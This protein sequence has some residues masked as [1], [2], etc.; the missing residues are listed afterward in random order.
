MEKITNDDNEKIDL[1]E[2]AL[3]AFE[4]LLKLKMQVELLGDNPV[5]Y[6]EG[7]DYYAQAVRQA[8]P[9]EP[10]AHKDTVGYYLG[11]D[12]SEKYDITDQWVSKDS[13]VTYASGEI[14]FID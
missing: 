6:R 5:L 11:L 1:P 2:Y 8:R 10:L 14:E 4:D 7:L 3:D 12:T 13:V 9:Q